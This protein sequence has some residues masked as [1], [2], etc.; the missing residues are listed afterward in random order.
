LA[1]LGWAE[2]RNLQIDLRF[3]GGNVDRMRANAAELAG[4]APDV[5]VAGGSSMVA[6]VQ[7]QTQRIPIVLI[8]AGDVFATGL[9][10]N[11]A[12]PEGNI[13]GVTNLFR[14]TVGKWIELLKEA[15][16]RVQRVGI[17]FN[18][19]LEQPSGGYRH[20]GNGLARIAAL[21]EQSFGGIQFARTFED[22]AIVGVKRRARREIAR[23]GFHKLSS[24]PTTARM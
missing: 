1:K 14:S 16:P 3:G 24:S 22:V 8:F 15:V 2:G 13:T 6:I 19:Q 17:I 5:I 21:A 4:L 10:K 18:P 20:Q 23:H 9:V 11:L 12:H 7:Q